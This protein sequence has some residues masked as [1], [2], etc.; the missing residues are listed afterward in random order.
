MLLTP[1][2]RRHIGLSPPKR[3]GSYALSTT[4]GAGAAVICFAVGVWFFASSTNHWFISIANYYH[5]SLDTTGFSQIKLHLF[6]T[7]PAILFSPIGEEIFFRGVLQRALEEKFSERVSTQL[8]CAT[9]GLVHLCHHGLTVGAIGI[10]SI[11]IGVS[12]MSAMLWV[13]LMFLVAYLFA[14]LRKRTDSIYPAIFSHATFNIVMNTIIF[15][16]LW[17][18]VG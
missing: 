8:E 5:Q 12:P 9:F 15:G 1:Y 17:Q 14:F 3:R 13:I 4:F 18:Y 11:H 16:Y 10:S 6:F 7:M 2:G